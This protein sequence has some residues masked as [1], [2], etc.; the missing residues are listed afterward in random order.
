MPR[1]TIRLADRMHRAL[2]EAAARQS[3]S[4]GSNIEE[5]SGAERYP[6][7]RNRQG[8]RRQ[9]ARGIGIER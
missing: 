4:M 9:G 1:L 6:T 2:K 7:P 8:D 3:R 5:S